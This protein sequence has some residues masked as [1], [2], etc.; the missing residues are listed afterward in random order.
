MLTRSSHF[1]LAGSINASTHAQTHC[2]TQLQ[3][4]MGETSKRAIRGF[5]SRS[6]PTQSQHCCIGNVTLRRATR[7]WMIPSLLRR[8]TSRKILPAPAE[9]IASKS[10]RQ[11]KGHAKAGPQVIVPFD[12]GFT[13]CFGL[14]GVGGAY[15]VASRRLICL[16]CLYSY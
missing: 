3:C 9:A 8:T 15:S 5:S 13:A 2:Q 10:K 7:R 4:S 6:D 14:G 1:L 16:L 11:G 12:P